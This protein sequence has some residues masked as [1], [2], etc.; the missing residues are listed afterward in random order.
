[1]GWAKVLPVTMEQRKMPI[2]SMIIKTA[3]I[4]TQGTENIHTK[5]P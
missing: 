2:N 5:K 1:M 3:I 4:Q